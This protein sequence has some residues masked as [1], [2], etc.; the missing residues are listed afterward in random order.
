MGGEAEK[1]GGEKEDKMR[2]GKSSSSTTAI[3]FSGVRSREL[4]R[5]FQEQAGPEGGG[6]KNGLKRGRE[7]GRGARPARFASA[8]S[9]Q[10]LIVASSTRAVLERG[11]GGGPGKKRVPKMADRD[12]VPLMMVDTLLVALVM[13]EEKGRVLQKKEKKD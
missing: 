9:L 10:L 7:G 11:R 3:S 4:R 2:G 12:L 1:E 13:R 6:R 5:A 8:S